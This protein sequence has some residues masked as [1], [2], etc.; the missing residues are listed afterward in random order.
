VWYRDVLSNFVREVLL[1]PSTRRR[2][3]FQGGNL[4][5]IVQDHCRGVRNHT[6]EIHLA[7][8]LELTARQL[9]DWREFD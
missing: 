8:S 2:P 4:E 1:D 9:I 7:L 5:K 3:Y 6:A